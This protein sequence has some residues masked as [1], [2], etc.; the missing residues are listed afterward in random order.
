MAISSGF[1]HQLRT[2]LDMDANMSGRGHLDDS[3]T[4]D[5]FAQHYLDGTAALSGSAQAIEDAVVLF[6]WR[7]MGRLLEALSGLSAVVSVEEG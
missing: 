1:E 4:I 7:A 5:S 6:Q 3:K 2:W